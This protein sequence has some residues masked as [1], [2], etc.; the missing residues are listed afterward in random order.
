MVRKKGFGHYLVFKKT[1]VNP[2][3]I[4]TKYVGKTTSCLISLYYVQ[5]N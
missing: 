1:G 4:S 5:I 2:D 3:L